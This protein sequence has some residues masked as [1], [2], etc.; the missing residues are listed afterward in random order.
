MSEQ[1]FREQAEGYEGLLVIYYPP[2]ERGYRA[3]L[4]TL[5]SVKISG[6][7]VQALRWTDGGSIPKIA[8]IVAAPLGYL[9]PAFL[10]HDVSLFDGLGWKEANKRFNIVMK[11]L[12]AP[13][14][15]RLIVINVVRLNGMFQKLKSMVGLRG[16]YV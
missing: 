9:F 11:D 1:D 14:I 16:R 10:V 8:R 2:R 5:E 13:I 3:I 15:Q 12:D 4:K 6:Y 7:T